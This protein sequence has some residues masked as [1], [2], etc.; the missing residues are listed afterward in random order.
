IDPAPLA[1]TRTLYSASPLLMRSFRY[2]AD[3]GPSVTGF[4]ST[5]LAPDMTAST[6][7]RNSIMCCLSRGLLKEDI[8]RFAVAIFPSAVIA[9]LSRVNG[10][11]EAIAAD[12]VQNSEFS[13]GAFSVRRQVAGIYPPRLLYTGY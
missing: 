11:R 8:L 9:R 3:P 4:R 6:V 1:I 10:R 2:F 13:M 5:V 7:A 12:S